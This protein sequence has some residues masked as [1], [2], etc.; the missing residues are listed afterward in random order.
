[1]NWLRVRGE[2]KTSLIEILRLQGF[3]YKVICWDGNRDEKG[4]HSVVR[5]LTTLF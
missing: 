5:L 1:M 3:V 4:A 2:G